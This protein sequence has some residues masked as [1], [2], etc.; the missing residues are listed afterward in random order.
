[1]RLARGDESPPAF[2]KRRVE[3]GHQKVVVRDLSSVSK[4]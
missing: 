4:T 2:G 3:L 1:M